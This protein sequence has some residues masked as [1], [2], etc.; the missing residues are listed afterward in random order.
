MQI[1]AICS[2]MLV[3][4]N[5]RAL[6]AE[7]KPI[8]GLWVIGNLGGGF[9]GSVDYSIAIT[10][11]VAGALLHLRLSGRA[12]GGEAVG[13]K[14]EH[15]RDADDDSGLRCA[16]T[17]GC[18][19]PPSGSLPRRGASP[20]A[21]RLPNTI[22]VETTMRNRF[23]LF[24]VLLCAVVGVGMG[25]MAQNAKLT[26]SATLAES[27]ALKGVGCQQC[28]AAGTTEPVTMGEVSD[29]SWRHQG[30]GA[31]DRQR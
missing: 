11:A 4:E 18:R 30:C 26:K 10:G 8:K 15:A 5:H 2:G 9:Y 25:A 17:V 12:A 28:H 7:G 13:G 29:L 27:H 24:L 22:G 14:T 21:K 16:C 1:S 6:D 3:D 31:K 20:D 19:R 23:F